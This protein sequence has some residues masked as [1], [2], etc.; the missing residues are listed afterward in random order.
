MKMSKL[1]LLALG[2]AQVSLLTGCLA[3]TSEETCEYGSPMPP[4]D[5]P[6]SGVSVV[7]QLSSE[8]PSAEIAIGQE[9]GLRQ[10]LPTKSDQ[11]PIEVSIVV[12]DGNPGVVTKN[13][14][15]LTE[16]EF[17]IDL[18]Q[19]SKDLQSQLTRVYRCELSLNSDGSHLQENTDL[20]GALDYAAASLT[21][22]DGK[23]TLY[24]FSNGL[25]TAGQIDFSEEFPN[26]IEDSTRIIEAL[27]TANALPDLQGAEV[28]WV[29][30]GVM[31]QSSTPLNQQTRNMLQYFWTQLILES[32]GVPPTEF[33]IGAISGEAPQYATP[34]KDTISIENVCVFTLGEASGFAFKPDS[35]EFLNEQDA[36]AGAKSI[37]GE[38]LAADCNAGVRV[39][40]YTASGTSKDKY[41]PADDIQLSQARAQKFADLLEA[42]GVQVLEVVG[43]GKGPINDW[44]ASGNF[45][46]ELGKLNRIVQVETVN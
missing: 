14:M 24:V 34:S 40:G 38:L 28:K 26:S 19:K 33:S 17:E 15:Q 21:E 43:G 20:L 42:E 18:E 2:L 46:E 44:D 25:Q 12:A 31:S 16:G 37:A 11:V 36:L 10:L 35:S 41:E 13:W 22:V 39:T 6:V 1:P 32:N 23:R 27:K 5:A 4:P 45:V 30:M 29:G 7:Y 3:L 8:F 9:T